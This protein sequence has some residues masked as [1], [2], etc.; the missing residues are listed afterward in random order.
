MSATRYFSP[1]YQKVSP[2]TTQSTR[3]PLPQIAKLADSR[4]GAAAPGRNATG[5]SHSSTVVKASAGSTTSAAT[6]LA[7]HPRFAGL[8]PGA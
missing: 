6:T 5:M 4:S 3:A 2:S 1:R 7:P 8:I